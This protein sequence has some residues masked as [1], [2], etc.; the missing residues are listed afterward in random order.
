MLSNVW[1]FLCKTLSFFVNLKKIASCV[2]ELVYQVC[3]GGTQYVDGSKKNWLIG[4]SPISN[5]RRDRLQ[6]LSELCRSLKNSPI[7]GLSLM[8]L[9]ETRLSRLSDFDVCNG[10]SYQ[11][12]I[13]DFN[14][15]FWP[16]H[17]EP[18]KAFLELSKPSGWFVEEELNL[19]RTSQISLLSTGTS[20]FL[21]NLT[22]QRR[23][24]HC[25]FDKLLPLPMGSHCSGFYCSPIVPVN[26]NRCQVDCLANSR[27]VWSLD[28]GLGRLKVWIQNVGF[29]TLEVL[30]KF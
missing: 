27:E 1:S 20:F 26:H 13:Q 21:E 6:G 18:L 9:N 29:Q 28:S 11:M 12:E 17:F 30:W 3:G 5:L 22:G 7:N 23:K 19:M 14:P 25:Q 4:S 15:P 8:G 2:F 16:T 10:F 24:D